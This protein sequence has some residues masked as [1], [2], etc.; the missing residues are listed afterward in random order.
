M[1]SLV[2]TGFGFF[3]SCIYNMNIRSFTGKTFRYSFQKTAQSC[4]KAAAFGIFSVAYVYIK[5]AWQRLY[6][7]VIYEQAKVISK[8][9]ANPAKAGDAKLEG[10]KA[11]F[12]LW[13]PVAKWVLSRFYLCAVYSIYRQPGKRIAGCFRFF[14]G[15]CFGKRTLSA[16]YNCGS[17]HV[18]ST[19]C[20]SGRRKATGPKGG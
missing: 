13:Q 12:R 10:L 15:D 7:V 19:L 9:I 11:E 4:A 1:R 18:N 16:E 5:T 17:S 8:L 3:Q 14:T 6:R 20:E 2:K